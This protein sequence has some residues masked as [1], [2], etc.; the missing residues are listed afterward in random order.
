M[1]VWDHLPPEEQYKYIRTRLTP[2]RILLVHCDFTTP[3]KDKFLVLVCVEPEP[4]FLIINSQLSEFVRKREW[5]LQCQ[6]SIKHED[7]SFLNHHSYI[8]C[9]SAHK[10][11]LRD[12]YEQLGKEIKRIKGE[13]RKDTRDQIC[14]AVKFSRTLPARHK[15]D[16]LAALDQNT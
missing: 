15:L 14:A 5:L 6:V 1:Q 11:T 8:D 7:Y 12:I 2:G 10:V 13:I 4:L 3:P 16:I 9:T